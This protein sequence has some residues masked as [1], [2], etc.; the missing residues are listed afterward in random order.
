MSMAYW[1]RFIMVVNSHGSNGSKSSRRVYK[2]TERL[3]PTSLLAS[4]R[5]PL[6]AMSRPH[7]TPHR[8]T[9]PLPTVS[10][11]YSTPH[12]A[13]PPLLDLAAAP[14]PHRLTQILCHAPCR[15]IA[16]HLLESLPRTTSSRRLLRTAPGPCAPETFEDVSGG[17]QD[18]YFFS[19]LF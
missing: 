15:V 1:A 8:A 17:F 7:S 12:R 9:P 5:T 19:E 6:P 16:A 13:A 4:A 18:N 10:H 3:N 11:L 2:I 14:C